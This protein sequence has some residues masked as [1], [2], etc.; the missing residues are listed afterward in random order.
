MRSLLTTNEQNFY[1][2]LIL[3]EAYTRLAWKMKFNQEHPSSSIATKPK[4]IR[5]LKPPV[6]VDGNLTLP[7]V[8]QKPRVPR[9][10][11]QTQAQAQERQPLNGGG[12]PLIMR[13]PSPQSRAALFQGV[14]NEGKGRLL[15]L[16]KRA[17]KDP[18]EKFEHPI[19]SSW[20]YGWRQG[21][22]E[23]DCRTPANGRSGIVRSTFYA[24]NGI[25]NIPSVTD[26]LG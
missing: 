4:T 16:R 12:A 14:S 10:H 22:F 2:E 20:E 6:V 25:F 21:D 17:Q 8:V 18:E 11:A 19:L 24:R 13:P 9:A 3:K 23:I 26:Q 1:R 7:P 15:Y 5:S